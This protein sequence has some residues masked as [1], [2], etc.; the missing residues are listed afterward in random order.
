MDM[1][2][3]IKD[4]VCK[5]ET[6]EVH[7]IIGD[8]LHMTR[9]MEDIIHLESRIMSKTGVTSNVAP[10]PKDAGKIPD[11]PKTGETRIRVHII[12]AT[13]A[14]RI[15][16]I[17]NRAPILV[18]REALRNMGMED[19]I[20]S[21]TMIGETGTISKDMPIRITTTV[22]IQDPPMA[23]VQM[24]HQGVPTIIT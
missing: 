1:V 24:D 16:R 6:K 22:D 8:Q 19:M 10:P 14:I 7:R 15:G 23:D 17:R 20:Q 2:L 4:K 13:K 11:G 9:I 5:E 3:M 21:H 12:E 18:D